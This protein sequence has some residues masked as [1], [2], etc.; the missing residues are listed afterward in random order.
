MFIQYV[1]VLNSQDTEPKNNATF[2]FVSLFKC[3]EWHL[4]DEVLVLK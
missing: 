3:K 1:L 4:V 2:I